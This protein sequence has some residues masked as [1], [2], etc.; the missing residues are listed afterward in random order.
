MQYSKPATKSAFSIFIGEV[1]KTLH[2][3]LTLVVFSV[4]VLLF[5]KGVS[6][7]HQDVDQRASDYQQ[8]Q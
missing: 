8:L 2:I 5:L 3:F 7:L 1:L 6:P 4:C